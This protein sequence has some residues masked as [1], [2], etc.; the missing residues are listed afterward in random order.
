[1]PQRVDAR[2]GLFAPPGGLLSVGVLTAALL[3]A[4]YA[5]IFSPSLG[6]ER[7]RALAGN[8]VQTL[9]ES[10]RSVA[11]DEDRARDLVV[12][13]RREMPRIERL[14][15]VDSGPLLVTLQRLEDALRLGTYDPAV[16]RA[17]LNE[18]R[19]MQLQLIARSQVTAATAAQTSLRI[20]LMFI[21][22][23]AA[24]IAMAFRLRARQAHPGVISVL[25]RERLG[26]LL[27][28]V[29]P[30]AVSI[31]DESECILAVNPAFCRV[32]GYGVHEAVG[33]QLG[34]N[35]T[36]EQD[37]RFFETMRRDLAQSGKWAGEIWQR[38]KTGEA[39]AEKV[40]R[41][42]I[43]DESGVGCGYLTVSMDLS[44]NK[45]AERLINWQAQHDTLTKLPNRTLL[46]ERL[47]RVLVPRRN[48]IEPGALLS[49]DIDRFKMVNDSIGPKLGDRLLIE[50]AM[51]IAM[52]A[53]ESDTVA[54]LGSDEF[55]VMLPDLSD[56][57]EAERMARTIQ[58]SLAQPFRLD[59]HEI[60]VTASVG[61]ALYPQDGTDSG[62]V[63]QRS[64][65]AMARSKELGGNAMVFYEADMNVRAEKRLLLETDLRR[66]VRERQLV[67]HYQPIVDLRSMKVVGAEALMRW[68]H[69]ERGLVPPGE[70]IPIAEDTGLIVD[71][72][73][74]LVEEVGAQMQR[75]NDPAL[76]QLRVS[77]N[78]SGR[79][80]QHVERHA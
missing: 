10:L 74:W 42:R 13:L 66:A 67:L 41:V 43:D 9:T 16:H 25:G 73:C 21:A 18:L 65:T 1:M 12:A 39:Y 60:V 19:A 76:S 64:N 14:D 7:D 28:E 45:D 5:W 30:E 62:S 55:A 70:F 50:A 23:L 80:L 40:T 78:V 32:T 22:L 51:R 57:A 59:G 20:N 38:R 72:G 2:S 56:Y 36:G 29:S 79:Q 52:A 24:A 15:G 61:I 35:G 49:I 69:P 48:R 75:W 54:R 4:W 58:T 8:V 31:A 77:I 46:L 71:M 44:A 6:L 26:Q 33:R 17:A 3:W 27:F 47:T 11:Y 34:F 53:R 37:D 68:M 63:M